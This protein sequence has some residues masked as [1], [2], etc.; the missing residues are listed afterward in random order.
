MLDIGSLPK[1]LLHDHLDG[2]LRPSTIIELAHEI[3]HELPAGEPAGLAAWFEEA[4]NSGSLVRYLET[5]EHTI[6]VMQAPAALSRVAREAVEDLSADGVIYAELR[7][8]PEQHQRRGLS[9]DATVA[10]VQEGIEHGVAAAARRGH[11]IL[12]NQIITAM[13]HAD[14][15]QEIAELAVANRDAGVAGFDIAGAEAGYPADRFPEVWQYLADESLP[16]TIHAGEADGVTS[17]ASA[18]HRGHA[19]RIGHGVRIRDDISVGDGVSTYGRTA[20]WIRDWRIPLEVCPS[21]NVQTGA[22][23]S[24]SAH[25]ISLL[26]DHDFAVTINT[27]NRLMSATSMTREMELLVREAGWTPDDLLGAT[28]TAARNAFIPH[29]ARR[30]LT[31]TI[32]AAFRPHIADNR[33]HTS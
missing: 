20:A 11:T 25:P 29:D 33:R 13:R 3:G 15:W 27:D 7:W 23:P 16:V 30:Q 21:S 14:R 18:I 8:A 19:L 22:A 31:E 2:G 26:R 6:A 1:V 12:V 4:A 32:L 10:A 24:I 17:V 9:L 28:L 5:F